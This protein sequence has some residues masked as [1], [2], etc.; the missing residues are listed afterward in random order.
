MNDTVIG[1]STESYA[2]RVCC[3]RNFTL[4]TGMSAPRLAG[5]GARYS[6]VICID[7]LADHRLIA[8]NPV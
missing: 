3:L 4:V 2:Q 5:H 7:K 8:V 6:F 1:A